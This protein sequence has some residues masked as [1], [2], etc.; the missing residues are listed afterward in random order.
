VVTSIVPGSNFAEDL[1]RGVDDRVLR[2]G[3]DA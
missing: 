3:D 1:D 2:R